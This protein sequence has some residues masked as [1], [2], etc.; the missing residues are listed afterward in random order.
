MITGANT[1]LPVSKKRSGEDVKD[2]PE[3]LVSKFLDEPEVWVD[4]FCENC[5]KAFRSKLFMRHYFCV[6]C[7]LGIFK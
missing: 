1:A 2:K 7:Y 3:S 6:E 5:G 4:R